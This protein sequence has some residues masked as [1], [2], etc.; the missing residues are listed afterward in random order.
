MKN[1]VRYYLIYFF[2]NSKI[3]QQIFRITLTH[4]GILNMNIYIIF[5]S[6]FNSLLY[7]YLIR[8]FYGFMYIKPNN[9]KILSKMLEYRQISISITIL[10]QINYCPFHYAVIC[11]IRF[12]NTYFLFSSTLI[13]F[14]TPA[15]SP[16]SISR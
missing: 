13:L 3:K 2:S 6:V 5:L 1:N 9:V 10:I 4:P 14:F 12:N 15:F 8:C 7:R 16:A 11:S